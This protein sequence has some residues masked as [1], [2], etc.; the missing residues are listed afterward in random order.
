MSTSHSLQ[1]SVSQ[2]AGSATGTLT[3]RTAQTKNPASLLSANHPSTPVPTTPSPASHLIR[4]AMAKWIV[5]TARMKGPSAVMFV[6]SERVISVLLC[7]VLS[8]CEMP[9]VILC[10]NTLRV[11]NYVDTRTINTSYC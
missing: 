9:K 7:F 3:A 2:R 10:S 8:S 1:A 4:S 5:L 11:Q 6:L